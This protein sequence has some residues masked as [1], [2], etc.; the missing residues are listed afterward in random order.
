MSECP[1][2]HWTETVMEHQDDAVPII[3]PPYDDQ[4][5]KTK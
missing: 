1:C 2:C 5:G 4:E 3:L